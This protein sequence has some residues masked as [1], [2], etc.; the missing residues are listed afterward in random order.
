MKGCGLQFGSI[1]V[2]ESSDGK[3]YN[4][5]DPGLDAWTESSLPKAGLRG[6]GHSDC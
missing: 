5:K 4:I 6:K 2:E 1:K 3:P